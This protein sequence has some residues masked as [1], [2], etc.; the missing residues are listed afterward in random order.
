MRYL[1]R[2]EVRGLARYAARRGVPLGRAY[3]KDCRT[4]PI[5]ANSFA[6]YLEAYEDERTA[7]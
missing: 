5:P 1:S 2:G 6:T 7:E 3:R 4:Y